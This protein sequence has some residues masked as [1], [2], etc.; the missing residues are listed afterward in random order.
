MLVIGKMTSNIYILNLEKNKYYVGKTD[1]LEKR[2]IAH[3]NGTASSWTKK[4]KPISVVQ[5]I[6]NASIFDEDKYT[7][8]YMAKYGIDNVR[9]GIY[10]TEA[11]DKLQRYTIKK[12]IW[13][14]N[15]CCTQCGRIGHF[16]NKCKEI[17]DVNGEDI[18]EEYP[19]DKLTSVSKTNVIKNP[20]YRCGRY[21]HFAIDCHAKN[22]INGEEI[23]DEK[24]DVFNC[25]YCNK[26]FDTL[27]GATAH[28]NLYCKHKK[29]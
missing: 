11:L 7:I 23:F 24:V 13:G 26:N 18:Y 2:E 17:K 6:P 20:C 9:G 3:F 12:F 8:E 1:N 19:N 29:K 15:D 28:E 16:V 25:R 5:I 10:V 4:Y 27:K 21:D 14:A 22:N